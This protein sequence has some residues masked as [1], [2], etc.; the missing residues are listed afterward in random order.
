MKHRLIHSSGIQA[1]VLMHAHLPTVHLLYKI[2]RVQG[3]NLLSDNYISRLATN[4]IPEN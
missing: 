3:V 2:E 1:F 4:K